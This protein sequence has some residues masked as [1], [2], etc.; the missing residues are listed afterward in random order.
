[1]CVTFKNNY[2]KFDIKIVTKLTD[3]FKKKLFGALLKI[4]TGSEGAYVSVFAGW[5]FWPFHVTFFK[6]RASLWPNQNGSRG[7][8]QLF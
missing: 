7:F 8:F 6:H 4:G 1:M 2:F 3:M 5:E